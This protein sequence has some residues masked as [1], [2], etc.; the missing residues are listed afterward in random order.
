[1]KHLDFKTYEEFI[2]FLDIMPTSEYIVKTY[3][4]IKN[5]IYWVELEKNKEEEK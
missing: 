2:D 3:C 5:N 4:D 1:M